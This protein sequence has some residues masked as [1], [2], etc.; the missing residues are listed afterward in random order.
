MKR[1]LTILAIGTLIIVALILWHPTKPQTPATISSTS[2]AA[3]P[4]SLPSPTPFPLSIPSLQTRQYNASNIHQESTV[5]SNGNFTS[6]IVSFMVDGL[7]EYALLNIPK[8][9]RPKDGYPVVIIAHGYIDPKQYNTVT[10]YRATGDY[11]ASQGYLVLKPDYR[12][13]ANSQVDNTALMRFAY[14]VDVMTLLSS[15]KNIPEANPKKIYI[16]GHS[17][18]G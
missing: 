12:G 16:W 2:P 3:S 8:S 6:S 4:S 11:F 1:I 13:N 9:P 10:S 18:G 14:P 17:M 7:K 15:V 5:S